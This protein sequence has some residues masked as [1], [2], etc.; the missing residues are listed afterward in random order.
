MTTDKVVWESAVEGLFVRG[1]GAR[2]TPALAAELKGHGLDLTKKLPLGLPRDAWYA[3]LRSA[4]R[5]LH[6]ELSREEAMRSLGRLTVDGIAQTFWGKAISPAVQLLGPRRLLMR[7]PSQ[8]RST[9][10]FATGSITELGSTSLALLVT[11]A[12]DAPEMMQGSLERLASWAGAKEVRVEVA[13][14]SPPAASYRI[15]WRS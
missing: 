7:V 15:S 10:N 1:V 3:C 5:H 4:A 6:P 12:G 8:M 13:P 11:D 2:L 14:L 9:N